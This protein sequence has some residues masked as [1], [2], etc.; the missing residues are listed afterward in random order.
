MQ[1]E[2][3]PI[4]IYDEDL[5]DNCADFDF[6]G[7]ECDACLVRTSRSRRRTRPSGIDLQ[8]ARQF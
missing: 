4:D 7:F 3:H 5:Q 2:A 6:T 1:N 8:A